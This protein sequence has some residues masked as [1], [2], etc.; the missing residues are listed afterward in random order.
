MQ[1]AIIRPPVLQLRRARPHQPSRVAAL[2]FSDTLLGALSVFVKHPV[3][4]LSCALLCFGSVAL[5]GTLVYATLN[6]IVFARQ[7]NFFAAAPGIL[8]LQWLVQGAVGAVGY[9][10]GR[11][12]I[13]W[14]AMQTHDNQPVTVRAAL[15]AAL[16]KWQPL[17]M[18]SVLYGAL[19]TIGIAG[20]TLLLRELRMD[21]SNF[22]W[23]RNDANS[24][25]NTSLVRSIGNLMPDPG[26]PFTEIYAAARYQLSRQSLSSSLWGNWQVSPRTISPSVIA[27]GVLGMLILALTE[28]LLCLRTAIIMHAPDARA[29]GWLRQTLTLATADARR[30]ARWQWSVRAGMA[31]LLAAFLVLPVAFHQSV[32]VSMLIREARAYWPYA[33][34]ISLDGLATALIGLLVFTF[35]ATFEA[36]MHKVLA[37]SHP[38]DAL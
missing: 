13:T 5:A 31:L 10:V 24:V 3:T 29:S 16:R 11:G 14:V 4:M 28:T 20:S 36:Q 1:D 7:D 26:S 18:S 33:L 8:A 37:D 21:V 27:A 2:S 19:I 38:T 32:F 30:V 35:N 12:A 34:N 23:I 6:A 9:L 15:R 25:L 17:L 22:R